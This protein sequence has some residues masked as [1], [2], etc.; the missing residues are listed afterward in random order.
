MGQTEQC[1]AEYVKS[2]E[3]Y[4]FEL[5]RLQTEKVS[6][7]AENRELKGDRVCKYKMLGAAM[8]LLKSME[9]AE[10]RMR[11]KNA[12]GRWKYHSSVNKV[13]ESAFNKIL[14]LNYKHA[15]KRFDGAAFL[16]RKSFLKR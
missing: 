16:L 1:F 9:Q 2:L 6:L 12:F 7:V 3:S 5:K 13:A 11:A 4:D 10:Y 8:V 15:D 14:E